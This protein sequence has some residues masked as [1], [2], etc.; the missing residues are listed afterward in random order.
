[1]P[2]AAV[3]AGIGLLSAFG[4]RLTLSRK[5]IDATGPTGGARP[6]DTA[7]FTSF[8]YLKYVGGPSWW[9]SIAVLTLGGLLVGALIGLVGSAVPARNSRTSIGAA[10]LFVTGLLT[11]AGGAL[12]AEFLPPGNSR[13]HHGPWLCRRPATPRHSVRRHRRR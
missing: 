12:Y 9:P 13:S 4:W 2:T 3:G 8:D 11:G 5:Y 10:A 7:Y 1:M 6:T